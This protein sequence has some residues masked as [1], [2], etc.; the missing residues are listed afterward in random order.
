MIDLSF[1]APDLR[2]L[3]EVS[4]EVV[5]CGVFR[6]VRPFGGLAGLLD[7]RLAGRLSRLA[8][9]GFLVGDVGEVVFLPARPRLPFEKLLAF[10]LGPRASF[11]EA[12]CR[13]V[14]TRVLDSLDGLVVKTALVELPGRS[15]NAIE[16]EAVAEILFDVLGSSDRDGISFVDDEDAERRIA[17]HAVDRHRRSLQ[18]G[19]AVRRASGEKTTR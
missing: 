10:G 9:Q 17:K 1:V 3:D 2:R 4:A 8:K 14:L 18:A 6:D 15:T 19:Q 5:A 12:A 13:Q 7:W 16:V 11:G